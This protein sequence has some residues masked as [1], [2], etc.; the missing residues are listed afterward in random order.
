MWIICFKI[1]FLKC[2]CYYLYTKLKYFY[3]LVFI[4]LCDAVPYV[5]G[6]S[7]IPL[8]CNNSVLLLL[9]T[10]LTGLTKP[11]T[12]ICCCDVTEWHAG[13]LR[14][15]SWPWERRKRYYTLVVGALYSFGYLLRDVA[16]H[17]FWSGNTQI[18]NVVLN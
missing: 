9:S 12:Q 13:K 6:Q 18:L 17:Y 2:L 1:L 7:C 8:A 3:I 11:C 14:Q 10:I 4:Y 5:T 16:E 15:Q